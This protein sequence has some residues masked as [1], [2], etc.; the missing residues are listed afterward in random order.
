MPFCPNCGQPYPVGLNYCRNCGTSLSATPTPQPVQAYQTSPPTKSQAGRNITILFF[1]LLLF[2]LVPIVPYS[3][4]NYSYLG[5]SAQ[6]TADV[7]PSFA[8][9]HCG[10]VVNVHASGSYLGYSTSYSLGN[11]GWVC[12]GSG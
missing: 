7:S 8:V 2:F 4:V 3:L 11:P 12:N 5:T 10:M 6:A 1:L 9:F